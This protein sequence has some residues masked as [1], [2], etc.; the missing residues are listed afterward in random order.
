[1]KFENHGQP[2]A[3]WNVLQSIARQKKIDAYLEVGVCWG[4]SLKC[5]LDVQTPWRLTLCDSWGGEYG[6]ESFGGPTHIERLLDAL[7]YPNKVTFLNGNSHELLKTV[8]ETFDLIT[9]DG[10]HSPEGAMEDLKDCWPLLEVGGMLVFDDLM[11]PSH[12]ELL[13]VFHTFV[14]DIGTSHLT[15]YEDHSP[16]GVGVLCK[17]L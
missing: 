4:H 17:I 12:P 6:G 13:D 1:M 15:M 14:K 11:H 9:V 8:T 7:K 2:N 5:L 3:L 16:M 10:D